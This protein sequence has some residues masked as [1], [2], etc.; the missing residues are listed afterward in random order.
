MQHFRGV[1]GELILIEYFIIFLPA[2]CVFLLRAQEATF[3]V[4]Y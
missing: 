4:D 1:A 2:V 3:S